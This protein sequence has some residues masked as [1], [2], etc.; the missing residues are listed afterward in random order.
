MEQPQIVEEEMGPVQGVHISVEHLRIIGHHGTIVAVFRA[1]LTNI[2]GHAGIENTLNPMIQQP[3]NMSVHQLGGIAYS[4]AGN[5]VLPHTINILIFDGT[6]YYLK[7]Q[8]IQKPLPK[9]EQLI[10]IKPHG[11]AHNAVTRLHI[12]G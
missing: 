3:F 2:I 11:N 9:G 8:M 10:H 1:L 6:G 5:G 12:I 4:V 7:A